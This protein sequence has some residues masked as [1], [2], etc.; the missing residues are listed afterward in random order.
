MLCFPLWPLRLPVHLEKE[1]AS[2]AQKEVAKVGQREG[3]HLGTA[4]CGALVLAAPW[5]PTKN[6]ASSCY[7]SHGTDWPG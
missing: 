1:S 6:T 4:L 7:V 3:H 5:I 2:V